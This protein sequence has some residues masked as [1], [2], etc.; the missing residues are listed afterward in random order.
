MSSK[1][2][3]V[4]I[5]ADW[6]AVG[7]WWC[8]TAEE[9]IAPAPP[10]YWSGEPPRHDQVPTSNPLPLPDELR[11][12][13]HRWND[14]VMDEL[15]GDLDTAKSAS[16]LEDQGQ[17]LALRVQEALGD[18]F[19]VL[20]HKE[21]RVHRVRPPGSWN[22]QTWTQELLGYPPPRPLPPS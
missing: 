10:G 17:E 18:D 21:G 20:F 4:I 8:L 13:L 3:R 2:R 11:E 9:M 6:G 7:I 16:E 22:A 14:E 12:Q 5:E 1:P 19:E 15:M